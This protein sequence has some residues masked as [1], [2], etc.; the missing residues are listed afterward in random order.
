MAAVSFPVKRPVGRALIVG[1]PSSRAQ[2][3][4]AMQA[5]GFTCAELED[6]YAAAAEVCRRPL[7]YRCVVLSLT[8]LFREELP[9]IATLK[10]R[11][12]HVEVW[13]T[14]LEG[15]QAALA[16][17]MRL[18]ADG[19]LGEDG[20]LHR[21]AMTAPVEPPASPVIASDA[22]LPATAAPVD[23]RADFDLPS[24]EPVL[25][26]DELRALLQEQPAIP[27]EGDA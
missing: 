1:N 2:P 12:P 14:H 20:A 15:R 24:G 17:A 11:L 22:D 3:L 16:E 13:L 6:P 8:S 9:V 23:D 18:G 25:S 26:A 7:V 27:P 21:T 4:A 19:L 10:R 5:L